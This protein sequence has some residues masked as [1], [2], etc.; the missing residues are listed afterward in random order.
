MGDVESAGHD[1]SSDKDH[2]DKD[3]RDATLFPTL[4]V[5]D[6]A[7]CVAH[8]V[9]SY[10]VF[11]AH[12]EQP[13]WMGFLIVAA[14][15]AVGSLRYGCSIRF[16]KANESLAL[17]SAFMGLPL[18]GL[19][20]A[21]TAGLWPMTHTMRLGATV[22][23]AVVANLAQAFPPVWKRDVEMIIN[24]FIFVYPIVRVGYA[25]VMLLIYMATFLLAATCING[26]VNS[27]IF[28][29]RRTDVF[30]VL[31]SFASLGMAW[32]LKNIPG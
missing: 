25:K 9:A 1:T 23:L 27:W 30:H 20:F 2:R 10:I 6:G 7:C 31:I 17:L 18:I 15:A 8:A 28:G 24:L 5:T 13:G 3:H 12:P 32:E 21:S 22:V 19:S 11:K 14:A 4:A 29:F 16:A 26:H